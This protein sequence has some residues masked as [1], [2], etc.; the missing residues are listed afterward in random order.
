[1][2]KTI[3]HQDDKFSIYLKHH[4]GTKFEVSTDGNHIQI[5]PKIPN[6][7]EFVADAKAKL[8]TSAA[9]KAVSYRTIGYTIKVKKLGDD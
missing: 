1:M 3:I 5:S 2:T 4:K 7:T 8:S 9:M 6:L